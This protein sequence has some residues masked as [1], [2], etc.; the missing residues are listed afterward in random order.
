MSVDVYGMEA[1]GEAADLAQSAYAIF[2]ELSHRWGMCTSL[3][4]L[5]F[6]AI[7]L[8]DLA[9]AERHCRDALRLAWDSQIVPLTLYALAGLAG[10]AARRGAQARAA[11]L[12]SLVQGH[13]Q[14][15]ALYLDLALRW[16]PGPIE[17]AGG[18]EST[19]GDGE[20]GIPLIA[21]A[22]EQVLR[23]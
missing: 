10:V 6:A 15:P 17:Q 19:G 13:P 5:G 2:Q 4:R 21:D 7:G 23:R 1:Y 20:G 9:G 8:G 12:F 16:S 18:V 11:E 14:M 3:C 22:V